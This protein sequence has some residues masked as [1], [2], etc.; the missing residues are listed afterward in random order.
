MAATVVLV[1]SVVGIL[2]LIFSETW[3]ECGK[4]ILI[5]M[6]YRDEEQAKKHDS[7]L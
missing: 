5:E 3:W 4:S 1:L 7:I 2:V 6:A